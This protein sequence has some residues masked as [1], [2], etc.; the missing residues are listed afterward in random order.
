MKLGGGGRSQ[1]LGFIFLFLGGFCGTL[2]TSKDIF[3]LWV[4]YLSKLYLQLM[5][6]NIY[7]F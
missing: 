2:Q 1:D 5:P 7:I 3:G 4:V 6:K